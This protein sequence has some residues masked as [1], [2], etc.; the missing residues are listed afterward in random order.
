MS[1][2]T[3][4]SRVRDIIEEH[5]EAAPESKIEVDKLLGALK[6][7]GVTS[8][9]S[10]ALCSWED[11]IIAGMASSPA[12]GGL[13]FPR[14]LAK[15]LA[16]VFREQ[17]EDAPKGGGVI[18]EKKA[19]QM[20]YAQL[21]EAYTPGEDDPV[22]KR[23]KSLS[24]DKAFVVIVSGVVDRV[25]T[26]RLFIELRQGYPQ[27]EFTS[28]G[29]KPVRVRKVGERE[30]DTV[31]ENPLFPGRALRPDG[32][33]DQC[34]RSY[35]GVDKYIRQLVRIASSE[36]GELKASVQS[37][38][39]ILDFVLQSNGKARDRLIQRFPK[40]TVRLGE[41]ERECKAPTLRISL[42]K[43]SATGGRSNPQPFDR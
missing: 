3:K 13:P 14:I 20:T 11:I 21:V 19:G 37:A 23:L 8:E 1:Y 22:A 12:S 27:R 41:L 33:C 18:S 39:D 31:D 42:S 32:T 10:M 7:A 43:A 30:D 26:L 16:D 17:A 2:D 36:T 34:L 24:D 9:A 35:E 4:L 6:S 5:N 15:R 40:A 25:E 38:H 28:V 29:G